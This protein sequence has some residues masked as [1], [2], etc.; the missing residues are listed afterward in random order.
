MQLLSNS[1]AELRTQKA[2]DRWGLMSH[3]LYRIFKSDMEKQN[4][5]NGAAKAVRQANAV[6]KRIDE[7]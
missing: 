1:L 7:A 5:E 3:H 2:A 4:V 6:E